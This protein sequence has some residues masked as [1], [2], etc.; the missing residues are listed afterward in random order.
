MSH[1][2]FSL[3]IDLLQE[4]GEPWKVVSR[5][6]LA[7][8]GAYGGKMGDDSSGEG[9]F[10]PDR[11]E[12]FYGYLKAHEK[13]LLHRA[14]AMLEASGRFRSHQELQEVARCCVQEAFIKLAKAMREETRPFSADSGGPEHVKNWLYEVTK[15]VVKMVLRSTHPLSLVSLDTVYD[16]RGGDAASDDSLAD[17]A[18]VNDLLARLDPM[19]QAIVE[20]WR[21]GYRSREIAAKLGMTAGAVRKQLSRALDQLQEWHNSE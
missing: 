18:H 13:G 2:S 17:N 11:Q 14:S 21:Q 10:D 9:P 4:K 5:S 12:E 6:P 20:L 7:S 1:Y 8:Y 16:I 19:K 3:H 15:N